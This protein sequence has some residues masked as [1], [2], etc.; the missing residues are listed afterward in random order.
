MLISEFVKTK[1]NISNKRYFTGL[2]YKYTHIGDEILVKVSDLK[3]KSGIDVKVKCDVCGIEKTTRYSTYTKS[4]ELHGEYWCNS[5]NA[6]SKAKY[7]VGNI[8]KYLNEF[9]YEL[10]DDLGYR[11][12]H[13]KI[14]IKCNKG[15]IYISEFNSFKNGC[16][17]PK[18]DNE[19]WIGENNPNYKADLTEEERKANES[20][21]S[22][23]EYRKW[24]RLVFKRDKF[25]C[26]CC[27]KHGVTLNAHHL[28]GYDNF[29]EKRYDINNGITLCE[30]CHKE[31]HH[32]YGYGNNTK[33]QFEKFILNR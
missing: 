31:F 20:R 2:G 16:R 32:I 14:K 1:W 7:S 18:C 21:H 26:K 12:M 29:K 3:L 30:D 23:L 22:K 13:N 8:S 15:H 28:D 10:I 9:G 25:T 17:C 5:C 4:V 11:T 27:G 24:F 6:K 19:R 33:Q